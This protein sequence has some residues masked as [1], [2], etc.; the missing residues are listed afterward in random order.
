MTFARLF[1]WSDWRAWDLR[2]AIFPLVFL[3]P[4]QAAIHGLGAS[5]AGV[6]IFTGRAVVILFSGLNLWLV[7]RI[8]SR[9]FGSPPLAVLACLLLAVSQLHTR[10]GSSELP[11]TVSSSF[12]LGSFL[13]LLGNPIMTR[14]L[15]GAALLGIGASIRFSEAAF[16]ASAALMFAVDKKWARALIVGAT[17]CV[18]AALAVG[19]SDWLYWGEPFHS[20]GRVVDFTLI[21]GRSSRGYQSPL[22]YLTHLWSWTNALFLVAAILGVTWKTRAALLWAAVPFLVLCLLPHKEARYMLPVL[23]FVV[24]LAA[25]GLRRAL[26]S[27]APFGIPAEASGSRVGER[28]GRERWPAMR[29]AIAP[30]VPLLIAWALL[31]ELGG[32]RFSRTEGAVDMA[33]YLASAAS[34]DDILIEQ[35]WKAGGRLYLWRNSR[36]RNLD[37]D[38][39]ER[40][41]P[42]DALSYGGGVQWVALREKSLRRLG[43]APVLIEEGYSEVL[44]PE[45]ARY[46]EYRLYRK[47]SK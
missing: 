41:D 46:G 44:S 19:V 18:A 1:Q 4:A 38:R 13:L 40:G 22:F 42:R 37:T 7:Y 33:R 39:L 9:L 31:F 36:A 34:G 26:D 21:E 8:A 15:L 16:I 27:L 47:S 43:L 35:W 23:P 10:L 29:R 28:M 25:G 2:N 45:G 5:D 3:Y 30:L 17:S 32:F 12:V 20:L 11:R 14:I 6:L 24:I